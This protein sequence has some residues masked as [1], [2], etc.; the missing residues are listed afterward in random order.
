MYEFAD[1][2]GA[3]AGYDL[4]RR[5]STTVKRRGDGSSEDAENIS[6]WQDRYLFIISG[7]SEDDDESKENITKLAD[8][9]AGAIPEHAQPPAVLSS[10]PM[11][12]RVKGSEKVV[13]GLLSASK[14]FS[15]PELPSLALDK[16]H[17]AAVADY[18]VFQP[19]RERM[20]L[21]Y[22]DYGNTEIAQAAYNAFV[23]RLEELHDAE[24]NLPG[25][26]ARVLFR[27]NKTFLLCQLKPNGKLVLISGA[28]KSKSPA[29]LASQIIER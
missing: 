20:K 11:M 10:L 22:I 16:A 6:F 15:A 24:S 29:L 14:Y 28:R 23:T 8:M 12:D 7:S 9:I 25:P 19:A 13:M 4:K 27:I 18:Q 17:A 26:D 5:G 2:D 3:N 1:S 21:L